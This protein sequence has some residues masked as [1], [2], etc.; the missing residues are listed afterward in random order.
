M[1]D[2]APIELTVVAQRP[3]PSGRR[4]GTTAQIGIPDLERARERMIAIAA[5]LAAPTIA[6]YAVTDDADDCRYCS[7]KDACRERPAIVEERFGR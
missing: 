6:H 2:V 3:R 5:S 7:Y 1:L 4:G